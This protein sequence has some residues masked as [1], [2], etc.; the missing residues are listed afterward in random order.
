MDDDDDDVE[1][2]D[3]DVYDD[4]DYDNGVVVLKF[5]R[6]HL[7][8][9]WLPREMEVICQLREATLKEEQSRNEAEKLKLQVHSLQEEVD[10]LQFKGAS[11]NRETYPHTSQTNY[12]FLSLKEECASLRKRIQDIEHEM[13]LSRREKIR[14]ETDY[15]KLQESYHELEQLKDRLEDRE[16]IWQLNLTDSQKE[17]DQCKGEVKQLEMSSPQIADLRDECLILRDKIGKLEIS[18]HEM[19]EEFSFLAYKSQMISACSIIPLIVLF[20]GIV[21]AFHPF[22]SQI[23]ATSTPGS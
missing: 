5:V 22:L 2:R 1:I 10:Y 9:I 17:S 8:D 23:T 16:L 4:N 19:E 7:P 13:G 18:Q 15:Y 21:M 6:W 3:V 14:L 20:F 12:E 11:D